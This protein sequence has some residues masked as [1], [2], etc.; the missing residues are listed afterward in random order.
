LRTPSDPGERLA[1]DEG[2][3]DLFDDDGLVAGPVNERR[4][5]TRMAATKRDASS[6]DAYRAEMWSSSVSMC[7]RCDATAGA[8]ALVAT[9]NRK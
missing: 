7:E 6:L 1:V 2:G 3:E 5:P 4:I 9:A 8:F